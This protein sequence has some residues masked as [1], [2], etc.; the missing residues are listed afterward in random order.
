[1]TELQADVT[2]C[3]LDPQQNGWMLRKHLHQDEEGE[4]LRTWMRKKQRERLAVYQKH[5]ESLREKERKPFSS[6]VTVVRMISSI[7]CQREILITCHF[8]K[9]YISMVPLQKPKSKNPAAIQ[10]TRVEKQKYVQF[11]IVCRQ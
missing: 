6:T 3:R 8:H 11:L 2:P 7:L 5:R 1:M 9:Y 4:E 10:E